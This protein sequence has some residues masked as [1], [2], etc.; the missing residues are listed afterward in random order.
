[1]SSASPSPSP[2]PAIDNKL[3]L[4]L[5]KE[6]KS[7]NFI[8]PSL[9][10][11][12]QKVQ[13]AINNPNVDSNQI[14][15]I[16]GTDPV[17]SGRIIQA[18]NSP[19]F[20]GLDRIEDLKNAVS[21]LGLVCVRNL[22]ISLTVTKLYKGQGKKFLKD[23]M[24]L[25][26]SLSIKVAAMS[27]VLARNCKRIDPAEAMLAGLLHN[28]GA[29][30]VLAKCAQTNINDTYT[31]ALDEA[32]IKLEPE[33]GSWIM[34]QWQLREALS[35]VPVNIADTDR[36]HDGPADYSDIVQVARL[37]AYRG[38][39]HPLAKIKWAGIPAFEKLNLTPEESINAIKEAQA[40]IK[41]VMQMLRS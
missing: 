34:D 37:H 6:L 27:E 17:L 38:T 12:A 8:L 33:L 39:K 36:S 35:S 25:I 5:E 32:L 13:S 18:A 40:D 1:M 3:L 30:P 4:H 15:K 14:A 31:D 19:L 9:P 28:I 23:K 24:R 20:R 7:R 11:S 26:W 2:S 21:R 29:I 22:V 10:D 41:E 16:I